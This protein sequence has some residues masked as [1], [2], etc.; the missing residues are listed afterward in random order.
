MLVQNGKE[1][2]SFAWTEVTCVMGKIVAEQFMADIFCLKFS[3][4][5]IN[6]HV[7]HIFCN[8]SQILAFSGTAKWFIIDED[9]SQNKVHFPDASEIFLFC[10]H[11]VLISRFQLLVNFTFYGGVRTSQI[12]N[13]LG[14][15][16]TLNVTGDLHSST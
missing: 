3:F 10:C 4:A 14:H 6:S 5:S 12:A 9:V 8:L 7:I 16:R 13:E 15:A 2:Q 11:F 1:Q